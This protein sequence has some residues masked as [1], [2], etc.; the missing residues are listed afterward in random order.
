MELKRIQSGND[1]DFDEFFRLYERVIN[2]AY[3][4]SAKTIRR[5]LTQAGPENQ[6]LNWE[7]FLYVLK[8]ETRVAGFIY[9]EYYR[10]AGYLFI[11]W[12]GMDTSIEEARRNTTGSFLSLFSK[13][14][15]TR[16]QACRS[17]IIEMEKQNPG[18]GQFIGYMLGRIG[19]KAF[20]IC[21]DYRQPVPTGDDSYIEENMRLVYIPLDNDPHD[22]FL[23]KNEMV[24]IL[25]CLYFDIYYDETESDA[26]IR[27]SEKAY[28]RRMFERHIQSLPDQ[29]PLSDLCKRE[30]FVRIDE[31]AVIS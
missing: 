23:S 9:F 29:I 11:G 15:Q 25:H 16:L 30:A 7:A 28:M 13:L 19:W 6:S 26:Q 31:S 24:R 27:Q 10:Q 3:Q 1:P 8:I 12:I 17:I 22:P 14:L 21:T 5:W 2:K 4:F 20:G 18:M